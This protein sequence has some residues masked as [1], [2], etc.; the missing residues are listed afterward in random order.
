MLLRFLF[1]L[2]F[3]QSFLFAQYIPFPTQNTVWVNHHYSF[4]GWWPPFISDE[5]LTSIDNFCV[6]NEDTIINS[7]TY[8]KLNYCNGDYRG[9]LRDNGGQVF[10]VSKDS[11]SEMLLYD[12][13]VDIGDTL[14]NLFMSNGWFDTLYVSD[15][16]SIT[17]GSQNH[18]TVYLSGVSG[19]PG[20]FSDYWVEGVGCTAGLLVEPFSNENISGWYD[21]LNCFST[22]D[23]IFNP[24]MNFI[25]TGSGSCHLNYLS[26]EGF[27]KNT[28]QLYPNPTTELLTIKIPDTKEELEIKIYNSMGE[29]VFV[30]NTVNMQAEI[31]MDLTAL[32]AGF[33]FITV[34]N[35]AQIYSAT[36]V[37][38]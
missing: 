25:Y 23:S 34:K 3:C 28:I 9:A 37:K 22:N 35:Q 27:S 36:F 19:S 6:N 11:L 15:I 26:L 21:E 5:Y 18:K 14:T 1:A 24:Q 13:T 4:D 17:I 31:K 29:V 20:G 8:T 38:N 33:Y 2:L 7:T 12:F 16:S 32:R 10:F 30:N